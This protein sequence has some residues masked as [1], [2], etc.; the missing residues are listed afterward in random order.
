MSEESTERKPISK[1][2]PFQ[3]R[4][5]SN[6]RKRRIEDIPDTETEP[7]QIIHRPL[8]ITNTDL[9][10]IVSTPIKYSNPPKQSTTLFDTLN[11][12]NKIIFSYI[13]L[14]LNIFIVFMVLLVIVKF[15]IGIK[16]DIYIRR[17]VIE[18]EN[19]YKI[20]ECKR[21]YLINKCAPETRVPALEQQCKEWEECMSKN[22]FRQEITKVVFRVA[23]ESIEEFINGFSLR[24][25][26]LSTL[27]TAIILKSLSR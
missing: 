6:G 18:E 10:N 20:E 26:I 25:I 12:L 16:N 14:I 9:D 17:A 19:N 3:I 13:L 15:T 27:A 24:T 1:S 11:A 2:H 22:P 8:S 5:V 4:K 21:E 23:S 7:P